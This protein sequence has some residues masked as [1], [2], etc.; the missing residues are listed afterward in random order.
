MRPR[1]ATD[2][3]PRALRRPRPAASRTGIVARTVRGGWKGFR[4]ARGDA[5]ETLGPARR[6]GALAAAAAC[7]LLAA[8]C[9]GGSRQD[10]GEPAGT[11][12]V[13]LVRA[14]FP[15]KQT[16]ARQ[17]KLEMVVR[18]TGTRTV[19]NLAV[20]LDSFAYNSR[21]PEL[22]DRERPVWAIERGAGGVASPPVES[23]QISQPGGGQTA[24]VNTWAFGPLKVGASRTLSWRVVPV[25]SGSWTVH[26]TLAAGLAGKAKARLASGD[27]VHGKFAVQIAPAPALTHVNPSTGHVEAGQFPLSP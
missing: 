11:F 15:A 9:G 17:A 18:N 12:A 24:Y 6:L 20:T 13:R 19:P 7:A 23:E 4:A 8:G 22:A 5:R 25:K 10:A 21:Y 1:H 16:I 14:S 2:R 26:Y 27:P 3:L